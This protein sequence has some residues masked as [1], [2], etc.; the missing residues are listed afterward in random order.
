MVRK[1]GANHSH[2]DLFVCIAVVDQALQWLLCNIMCYHVNHG[3]I[4]QSACARLPQGGNLSNLASVGTRQPWREWQTSSRWP[5]LPQVPFCYIHSVMEQE[6]FSSAV[7][8]QP[9]CRYFT[10]TTHVA[11]YWRHQWLHY[12]RLY[13]SCA[14]ST[15]FPTG[16]AAAGN[17]Q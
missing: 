12:G 4:N 1:Q 16:A 9:T 2:Q 7:A 3:C 17:D 8:I 15:L 11:I 5:W 14:F 6:A 10:Y 13:H